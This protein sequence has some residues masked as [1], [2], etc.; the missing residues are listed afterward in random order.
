MYSKNWSTLRWSRIYI[1]RAVVMV[2]LFASLM[3]KT[4]AVEGDFT[5]AGQP[6][7]KGSDSNVMNLGS[8]A[9]R[10]NRS[11]LV[12]QPI[13][14]WRNLPDDRLVWNVLYYP[15]NWA[16]NLTLTVDGRYA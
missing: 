3:V 13:S 14:T 8:I 9:R 5:V 16:Y 10:P 11:K 2:S 7:K 4:L 1:F 12:F 6:K 15:N